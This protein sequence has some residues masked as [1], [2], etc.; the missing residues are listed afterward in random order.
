MLSV[1]ELYGRHCEGQDSTLFHDKEARKGEKKVG[2]LEYKN[3]KQKRIKGCVM[4]N[5]LPEYQ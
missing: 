2:N 5:T 4:K 3:V 1:G